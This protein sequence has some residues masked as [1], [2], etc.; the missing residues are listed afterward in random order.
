MLQPS[1]EIVPVVFSG[2]EFPV[3]G[4]YLQILC[5]KN[6]VKNPTQVR[7]VIYTKRF[8]VNLETGITIGHLVQYPVTAREK[9]WGKGDTGQAGQIHVS[10]HLTADSTSLTL[11]FSSFLYL[12]ASWK[13]QFGLGACVEL[14]QLQHPS[15]QKCQSS[16][17]N[18]LPSFPPTFNFNYFFGSKQVLPPS[19]AFS[20][21]Y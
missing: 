21:L 4:V 14:Q 18:K 20:A 2:L 16:C 17:V 6:Q 3:V 8:E 9:F 13:A 15:A 7:W 10:N 11:D 1:P 19:E 5:A 12:I